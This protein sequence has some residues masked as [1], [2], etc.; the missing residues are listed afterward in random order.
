M[1]INTTIDDT[2]ANDLA[3][4]LNITSF[5]DGNDL[6]TQAVAIASFLLA[7]RTAILATQ[8][9]INQL[10]ANVQSTSTLQISGLLN[11]I[12]DIQSG[13]SPD[14]AEQISLLQ[15]GIGSIV[16]AT[17]VDDVNIAVTDLNTKVTT[18][19]VINPKPLP[20]IIIKP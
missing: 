8:D 17:T 1:K 4:L 7:K 9:A 12:H 19:V 5:T 18:P 2:Q 20:P 13:I 15:S 16:S 6:I 11:Q 14:D 10:K 3:T